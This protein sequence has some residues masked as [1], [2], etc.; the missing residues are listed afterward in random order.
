MAP[1]PESKQ[2]EA[3]EACRR[4][5][6]LFLA[7][8][9]RAAHRMAQRAQT[10][11]P[12]LPGVASALAAYAVHA[13][14][15]NRG[16][17]PD[18]R[19]VLGLGRAPQHRQGEQLGAGLSEHDVIRRQFRR[20][21]LLVHPDKNPS[22]AADG[23]FKLLRQACD[24]LSATASPRRLGNATAAAGAEHQRR[25]YAMRG[26]YAQAAA[27]Y[28][29]SPA[30]TKKPTTATAGNHRPGNDSAAKHT[31]DH[32]SNTAA[33]ASAAGLDD[34]DDYYYDYHDCSGYPN[35]YYDYHGQDTPAAGHKDDDDAAG[36]HNPATAYKDGDHD[37]S[38]GPRIICLSCEGGLTKTVGVPVA[39]SECPWCGQTMTMVPP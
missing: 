12:A 5:E 21:S 15:A 16:G 10:L 25:S 11:C 34:D 18:W 14:A 36:T 3:E 29:P 35:D 30:T 32:W 20:M 27:K 17:H 38:P 26:T 19:A 24:A 6:A 1:P 31:A 33:Y 23:A 9:A 39:G 22:V 2:D 13:A 7:G 28:A 4:A 37:G 8:D